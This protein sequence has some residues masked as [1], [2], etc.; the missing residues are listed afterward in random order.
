MWSG[1]PARDDHTA[2]LIRRKV[3]I[4][5]REKYGQICPNKRGK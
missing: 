1:R 4:F 3:N 5:H 2:A